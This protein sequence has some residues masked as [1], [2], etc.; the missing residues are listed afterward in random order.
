MAVGDRLNRGLARIIR[1]T[2]IL[3]F[4]F[5]NIFRQ[6]DGDRTSAVLGRKLESLRYKE[7]VRRFHQR[8]DRGFV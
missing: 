5:I 6:K 4:L 8:R 1:M 3:G 7:V 2:R